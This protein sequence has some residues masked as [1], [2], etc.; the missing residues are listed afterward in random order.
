[1]F[2]HVLCVF[3][4]RRTRSSKTSFP[5]LGLEY[6]A[7]ALRPYAGR[8]DLVNF[9]HERTA[10]TRSFLTPETDLVCYSINWREDLELIRDDINSLPPGVTTIV[11][12]RTAT[13]DPRY[14]MDAC[15]NVDAVVCGDGEQAITEIAA[16]RAW[17][18]ITG[19]VHRGDDGQLVFNPPRANAPLDNDL[20]PARDLRRGPYYLTSKG[21]ST[22]IKI[23]Q[24][25]G[26][27]GCPFNCKFCSFS[28]NPWG[29]K[30][31]WTPRTAESVVRE[32][33]SID[34]DLVF[35]V[36]DVFAH[37]PDRTAAICDLLIAKG[38]RKN[39]VANVRL[40]IATH[41]DVLRKM[42]RAGFIALL[43]GVESTQDATLKAMGKGFTVEQIRQRFEVLRKSRMILNAYFIVGNI[44]ESK[45]QML[46][47]APFARSIGVDLVHVSRLRSEPHSGLKALVEQTPGYHID[48]EGFVYSDDCSSQDIAN[49]RKQIDREFHRPLH[50]ARVVVKLWRFA[51]WRVTAK[52]ALTLPVFFVLLIAMQVRR[53]VRKW[54][55]PSGKK[56]TG[57]SQTQLPKASGADCSEP[58]PIV[59]DGLSKSVR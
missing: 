3:P 56:G 34:A 8:I 17:S 15:P 24:I 4:Y 6:I 5:P 59:L 41:P 21:V 43:I 35:F 38:I 23:D 44:G 16:G 55:S 27:R 20:M 48:A 18:D 54:L 9:R 14:W 19:L 10:R 52:A 45:E 53:K 25:V 49:V 33:E 28:I 57:V 50:V 42:E 47:I 58:V 31:R 32:I 22:G 1:M 11:G 51:H 40:E 37:E 46:S 30:R 12:G 29:V 7:A 26:S 39:Y 2:R 13:E 36:D